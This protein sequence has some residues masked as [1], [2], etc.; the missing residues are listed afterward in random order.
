MNY[1]YR[2]CPCGT[3]KGIAK[4]DYDFFKGIP[5]ARAERWEAPVPVTKWDEEFNATYQ[6]HACPQSYG[7]NFGIT[8]TTRFY[9]NE[10]VEKHT[11]VYSEDCLNLNI[12]TPKNAENAPVLVFIHG[13][14]YETGNGSAPGFHG[15]AYCRRGV[16]LVTINYRLNA[17]AGAIGDGHS[18]NYG[19][20]DQICALQWIQRNI[21]GFGGDP[22]KVTIMGESA[23]AMSVQNLILS[24]MAKGLFRA[25]ILHSGGGIL[26]RA[27][28]IK[29]PEDM[30]ALWQEVKQHFG[31]NTIDELK[32]IPP[33]ELFVAWKT[34][35]AGNRRYACPAV[36]VIDGTF[37]PDTPHALA[38]AGNVNPVPTIHLFLSEDMWPHTLYD[39]I[40]QWAQLMEKAGL[41][42]VY[43][44]Y[45]DRAAPGSDHGAFHACDVK[46]A[47]DTLDNCWRP[48]TETDY[49]ISRNMIDYYVGFVKTGV[50]QAEDLPQWAPL[51]GD[52]Q[53]F[54]HFGDAPCAMVEVPVEQLQATEAKGKPFPTL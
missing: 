48:F 20:Q 47:F 31:V 49:R 16:I 28:R 6:G 7:F 36:P 4:E 37:I 53:K 51:A 29:G 26:P 18:G 40:T 19:L 38:E 10:T 22:K 50:P 17:F 35:S 14:S 8:N 3:A 42:P 46:Y 21:A 5:F 23:G 34:I 15:A 12:L 44:A 32:Q 11:V 2:K 33:Q 13:G 25:A 41:P 30:I 1:T 43:G 39:T 27:F 52:Q 9:H 54:M 45:F 24:P